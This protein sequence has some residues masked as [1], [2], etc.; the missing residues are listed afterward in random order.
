M[1]NNEERLEELYN[2]VLELY[3]SIIDIQEE[4]NELIKEYNELK[5][6]KTIKHMT[7]SINSYYQIP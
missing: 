2:Q 6:D 7:E 4:I 5:T 1:N 3:S